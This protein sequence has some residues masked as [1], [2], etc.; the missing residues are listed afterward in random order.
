MFRLCFRVSYPKMFW[1]VSIL[2]LT[3]S[4]AWTD[5]T[6]FLILLFTI[7][8]NGRC[9]NSERRL[10]HAESSS[11]EML[12]HLRC[13][14]FQFLICFFGFFSLIVV[15]ANDDVQIDDSIKALTFFLLSLS[16]LF[17]VS[18][19][20]QGPIEERLNLRFMT[21]VIIQAD[22]ASDTSTVTMANTRP[23]NIHE[24][25]ETIRFDDSSSIGS[26]NS[27]MRWA[28]GSD[29]GDRIISSTLRN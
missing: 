13:L 20:F 15:Y 5:V 6:F 18:Q 21:S 2:A 7:K 9:T 29:N 1:S 4:S 10:Q 17:L 12:L 23:P 22:S 11:Y 16:Y 14:C 8:L 24:L 19:Y 28:E 27:L 25:S 3:F 26:I